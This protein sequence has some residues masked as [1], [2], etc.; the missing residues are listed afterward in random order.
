MELQMK[1]K[2][3]LLLVVLVSVTLA[4]N[5]MWNFVADH[6]VNGPLYDPVSDG[7]IV[8]PKYINSLCNNEYFPVMEDAV[9]LYSIEDSRQDVNSISNY[10]R[11]EMHNASSKGFTLFTKELPEDLAFSTQLEDDPGATSMEWFCLPDGLASTI[12]GPGGIFLPND[13]KF[14]SATWMEGIGTASEINYTSLGVDVA[15]TQAGNYYALK[16]KAVDSS[17]KKVTVFRWFTKDI[18]IV[19]ILIESPD[20]RRIERLVR[21]SQ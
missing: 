6:L 14:G 19:R 7:P 16:V 5:A 1:R 9:W 2:N 13:F 18:G 10:L 12:S 4:C 3:A 21:F 11:M 8:T 20:Y 15:Y 17:E